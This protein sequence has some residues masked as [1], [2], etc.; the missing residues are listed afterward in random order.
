M[1]EPHA[2]PHE[3]SFIYDRLELALVI[4]DILL[5]FYWLL[6]IL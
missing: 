4:Y 1:A 3:L 6:E 2:L 5:M